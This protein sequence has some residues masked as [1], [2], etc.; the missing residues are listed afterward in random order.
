MKIYNDPIYGII[1]LDKFCDIVINH[2]FFQ[3]LKEIKQLGLVYKVFSNVIHSRYEH[4]IGVAHLCKLAITKLKE[5]NEFITDKIVTLVTLAGLLHDVGHGPQSHLFDK[6]LEKKIYFNEDKIYEHETRSIKI[7]E[8]I[9]NDSEVLL[10][11]LN[12]ED[13]KFISD[14]IL[15]NVVNKSNKFDCLING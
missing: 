5:D 14:M 6:I 3:R 7:F 13:V 4:S 11:Y 15:G 12:E 9:R 1:N 8:K 2:D 10:N